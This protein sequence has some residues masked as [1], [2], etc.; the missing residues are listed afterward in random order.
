MTTRFG[1]GLI[2]GKFYPPHAGHLHLISQAVM[3]C[4]RVTVLVMAARR[5]RDL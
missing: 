2:V 5:E 3:A 4:D 1:H